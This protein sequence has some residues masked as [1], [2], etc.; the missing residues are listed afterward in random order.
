MKREESK[1]LIHIE[2]D[3]VSDFNRY[4]D[5]N[6]EVKANKN[7]AKREDDGEFS[8]VK[9][10]TEFREYL[11]E[12]NKEITADI[13][14]HTKYYTDK[15]EQLFSTNIA[16]QFDVTGEFFDI[17]AVMVGE[18]EAWIKQI[19]VKEDKFIELSIQGV[20]PHTVKAKDIQKNGSKVFSIANV[21]EQQ[22]YLVRINMVY[23]TQ[24]FDDVNNKKILDIRVMAKDYNQ[25][26]DYKKFGILLGVPF[27]RRGI[28][29][30]IEV[31]AEEVGY[32][33]GSFK[34]EE[35]EISLNKDEDISELEKKLS[36]KE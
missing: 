10:W 1:N 15:F 18:P 19:E 11:N 14:K 36:S 7:S 16:Y 4:L 28:F 20:Y 13:R 26:L 34:T 32:G 5:K 6:E 25:G 35:G 12:G 29:R 22:G 31:E 30:A 27:F 17:G 8:G 24:R 33:Y 21:L 2:F 9:S 23:R 3:N